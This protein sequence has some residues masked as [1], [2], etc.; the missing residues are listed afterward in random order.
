MECDPG[1]VENGH[2]RLSGFFRR[3]VLLTQ[4]GQ[5][6]MGQPIMLECFQQQGG[7]KRKMVC[8]D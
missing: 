7:T 5:D 4:V 1:A 3:I 6:H 8:M 2:G